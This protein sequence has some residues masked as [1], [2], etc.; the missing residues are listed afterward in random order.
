MNLQRILCFL[1]YKYGKYECVIE[2]FNLYLDEN[3]YK[4]KDYH[5][6]TR[7]KSG[8]ILEKICM[9]LADHDFSLILFLLKN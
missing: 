4:N 3:P 5:K 8:N 2:G 7:T 1:Y 6:L 9:S